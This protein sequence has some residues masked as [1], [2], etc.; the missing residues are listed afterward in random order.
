MGSRYLRITTL[1]KLLAFCLI[2]VII[3]LFLTINQSDSIHVSSC[4]YLSC[5]LL[6]KSSNV[7]LYLITPTYTRLTQKADLIRLSHTLM[8]IHNILWIVVEDR[9]SKSKLVTN[10]LD[11]SGIEHVHMN[12]ETPKIFRL[13][14]GDRKYMQHRGVEQRNLALDWIRMS[15]EL[16]QGVVYFMD[17]DNTYDIELFHHIRKVN[18]VG[19]WP[20]GLSGGNDYEGPICENGK[21]TGW[22]TIWDTRRMFPID[23]S[24]FAIHLQVLL[25]SPSVYWDRKSR[26]GNLES[27]LL[28]SLGIE[29]GDLEPIDDT[30][31]QVLVWHTQTVKFEYLENRMERITI[32]NLEKYMD[33]EV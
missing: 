11:R 20:V 29:R 12:V 1:L 10:L 17:D 21:V 19:I 31:S 28:I 24:G 5:K 2:L 32:K 14:P 6:E 18:K 27:D 7:P 16:S 30:C 23:M 9:S 15:Y 25:D 8:H 26:V 22:Y 4:S 3:N 33:L 13:R